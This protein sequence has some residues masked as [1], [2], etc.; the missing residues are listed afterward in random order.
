MTAQHCRCAQLL[1]R[2]IYFLADRCARVLLGPHAEFNSLV[3]A[4]RRTRADETGVTVI[5]IAERVQEPEVRSAFRVFIEH[6]E[7]IWGRYGCHGVPDNEIQ[8]S[9]S[10][11]F[12]TGAA[13]VEYRIAGNE[14]EARAVRQQDAITGA[15]RCIFHVQLGDGVVIGTYDLNGIKVAYVRLCGAAQITERVVASAAHVEE[16]T[17]SAVFVIAGP[18]VSYAF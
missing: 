7:Y 18:R 2:K 13:Q 10:V 16:R 15:R 14:V 5:F 11:N 8:P 3:Y 1:G 17:V 9:A 4:A 6:R 12:D